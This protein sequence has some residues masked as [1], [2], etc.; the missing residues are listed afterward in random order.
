M[1]M[2]KE[3]ANEMFKFEVVESPCIGNCCLNEEDICLGCYRSLEEITS[4]ATVDNDTRR[5]YIENIAERKAQKYSRRFS[6]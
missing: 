3:M 4:W 6:E 2:D 1:R 5:Q